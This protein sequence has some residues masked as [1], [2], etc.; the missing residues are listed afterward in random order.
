MH[1]YV[2]FTVVVGQFSQRAKV[3]AM[4]RINILRCGI[5]SK[6]GIARSAHGSTVGYSVGYSVR[7][8]ADSAAI[9]K[10]YWCAVVEEGQ[11]SILRPVSLQTIDYKSPTINS[12]DCQGLSWADAG[13][14]ARGW[15]GP[16]R[17]IFRG[18][19]AARPSPHIFKFSWPGQA[20]PII[21]F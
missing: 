11:T 4:L 3:I 8:A 15:A 14:P 16:A 5:N 18:W 12:Y 21:F 1:W 7:S 6:P 17:Q 19:A 2:L 9:G 20:R 13:W 10:R